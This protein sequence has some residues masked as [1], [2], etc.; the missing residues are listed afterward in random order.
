MKTF[1]R[2]TR[3]I[4]ALIVAILFMANFA[5]AQ[6]QI[7][8][9]GL[10][11]DGE[12][13]VAWNNKKSCSKLLPTTLPEM[14]EKQATFHKGM[15]TIKVKEGVGE[16]TKQTG[17][18]SFN[19]PSLDAKAIMYEIN[20]LEK[21]FKYNPLKLKDNL[22]DLSRIYRITFPEKHT[23]NEV[24]RI[25]A[26][27][28]NI[29]YAEPIPLNKQADEPDDELYGQCQHLPQIFAHEAWDIFHGEDGPETVIAIID[30]GTY[31][32]H[33]DLGANI[34]QNLGEDADGDGFTLIPVGSSFI[35]DPDDMN[36]IDDD[37][38]GFTDDFIGWDMITNNNDPDHNSGEDHG[39]HTAGIAAGVT[40]NGTGIS[41]ISWNVKVMPVQVA[42]PDGSFS[43]AYDGIIYAAENG[44]DFISNSWGGSH[45]SLANQ[46]VIDYVTGLGSIVVAAA[47]NYNN[48][49]PI[50]PGSYSQV[51]SVASLSVDDTKAAYSNYG[52]MVD[53]SCPGGGEEGGILSTTPNN[54]YARL[55]GTSMACPMVAGCFSLLK[56]YRPDWTSEQLIT[57]VMGTADN[58][59]SLNPDYQYLLGTGRVNALNMLAEENVIMPQ[60]LKLELAGFSPQDE[61]GNNVNEA[62]EKVTLNFEFRNYVPY[63]G[64]DNVMVTIQSDDPSVMIL[65]GTATVN[66]PPEGHF[67]IENQFRIQVGEDANSHFAQF[68]IH[69]Q[70]NT[71][72]VYG[73]D[74]NVELLVAPAGIF[75]FEGEEFG[76][77][78]S[79][80]YFRTFLQYLGFYFT[81]SNTFPAS[82]MGFETVFLSQG[83]YGETLTLGTMLT[84]EN[85]LSC[86]ELLEGGGNL[87]IE[88]SGLFSGMNYYNYPN[89]TEM[90]QL[91]GVSNNP[92]PLGENPLDSLI[93]VEGSPFEGILFTGSSQV[94]NWYIDKLIP[95]TG[96][97]IP[98]Y[99]NG[100]GNVSIMNDGSGSYGHKTFYLGY[101]LADLIDRDAMN[102]RYNILLKIMEF[103][104]YELPEAYVLPNFIADKKF[105]DIPL[106]VQFSD[107]S[108]SE[109]A[110]PINSWQWDFDGDGMIDSEEQNPGWTYNSWDS[111]DVMLVVSNGVHSDTLVQ[112]DYI[113]INHGLLVY[114]GVPDGTGNSGGFI[115]DYLGEN[116]FAVSYQNTFPESLDGF[117]A[118][119][120]SFGNFLANYTALD[121]QMAA[122]IS[123]Y[124]ENGGCVYLEGGDALGF[125][126]A[127]NNALLHL[128]GVASAEDGT[129]N[130]IDSLTGQPMAI[131]ADMLFNSSSQVTNSYIDIYEPLPGALAAFTESDYGIVAVQNS[132]DFG[133][134]TFCFSYA[135]ADLDDA[136]FPSTRTELLNRLCQFFEIVNPL[137]AFSADTTSV[138]EGDTI[139]FTDLS[140][141]NPTTWAWEFEGGTP[142]TSTEQNPEIEYALPG[143][144][145]V[146]LI[147][148]NA[149]GSDTL[150]K[151]DYIHVE[152]A[153]GIEANKA[154]GFTLYPNPA[155]DKLFISCKEKLQ[156]VEIMN[157]SGELVKIQGC[158]ARQAEVNIADL[159][160]GM[161]FIRL[162]TKNKL[163][164][165]K[166]IKQ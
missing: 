15:I 139:Y 118:A 91:F 28:P 45:Y 69:F 94:Q 13:G 105:G 39:T 42:E 11:A 80:S 119:F 5:F 54:T 120:L 47:H 131:T 107:I 51:I 56:S 137:A 1:T 162:Q 124:L 84:E 103:F 148:N 127:G 72:V 78:Y 12:G 22:P 49:V 115:R 20:L 29:E 38:N 157:I 96:A 88:M 59:D 110:Y 98:F 55:S 87:Y 76:Q 149:F 7:Q 160:S 153:I 77:D 125:D 113:T 67:A 58:I 48:Q 63:V 30:N 121:N 138:V 122:T 31:W 53:I 158:K 8:F 106:E 40:N 89:Y 143:D 163:I 164:T 129:T 27:D 62:G 147:V 23:V 108:V 123:N 135:F 73:Q 57:Q 111:Y 132:G 14:G 68:T 150:L 83:N 18:V 37:M 130:Y 152:L 93:G 52:P 60:E 25:F 136:A 71:P 86:Q 116:A 128:F 6:D 74:I 166:I 70:T 102:S 2:L 154:P 140:A 34:W 16:F 144:Y 82:L 114:E 141:N 142:E 109:P 145:D 79:G 126:Q 99:E 9:E 32:K 112:N 85:A 19:I 33:V 36:G 44:A 146:K 161:Y 24:V 133:Q 26:S 66:I 61:N 104:G 97:I 41:S 21:R 3:V 95:A 156:S 117:A 90:K 35:F 159:P 101:A 50:Y 4:T 43:G 92:L 64:E 155:N 151:T 65:D 10:Y 165:N 134:R 75:I 17:S 81:Y 46:E 100:Y